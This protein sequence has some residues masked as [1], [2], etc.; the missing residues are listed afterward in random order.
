MR[1]PILRL[2]MFPIILVVARN[3]P[4]QPNFGG[5]PLG[6]DAIAARPDCISPADRALGAQMIADYRARLAEMPAGPQAVLPTA[7]SPRGTTPLLRFYPMAGNLWGDLFTT[8]FVD[9]AP[10]SPAILDWDCTNFTYDGHRG[11]DTDIRTFGEQLIG[12]P[13][14]AALDGLVVGVHDGE[15]DM[16]TSWNNQPANF[17][18]INHAGR[19]YWYYH[20][21]KDSVAVSVWDYVRAGTQIGLCG[22]SGVSTWPH[23]HFELHRENGVHFEPYA[24]PCRAGPSEWIDQTPIRRDLYLREFTITSADPGAFPPLPHNQV[25]RTGSFIQ[26]LRNISFWTIVH[27]LPAAST[28]RI[29]YRRPDATIAFDTGTGNFNN[30]DY[31]WSWWYWTRT[32]NFNQPGTWHILF[33]LNGATMIEA[34]FD[35]LPIG[36]SIVNRPPNP[37]SVALDPPAPTVDD[38]VFCRVY[39]SLVLDDPDYEIVRYEYVWLADGDEVR[40]VTSAA[41]SDA[42]PHHTAP[43]GATLQCL[44]TPKDAAASG[45]TAESSVVALPPCAEA[46]QPPVPDCN[47][48]A[49]IDSCDIDNHTSTDCN[50]NGVPD[51]C[52]PDAFDCDGDAIP[53]ICEPF[54]DCNGNNIRDNCEI[55]SGLATDC[56]DNGLPDDCDLAAGATDCDAN[57]VLDEC[58]VLDLD[59]NENGVPDGCDLITGP[60]GDCND[61]NQPDVNELQTA[62]RTLYRADSPFVD[63]LLL[64]G[65]LAQDLHF[66]GPC[67]VVGFDVAHFSNVSLTGGA[68]IVRFYSRTGTEFDPEAA[69]LA[70]F[71]RDD[72]V[73][74]RGYVVESFNL[75][76]AQRFAVPPDV[77]LE[78][79]YNQ[80]RLEFPLVSGPPSVGQSAGTLYHRPSGLYL[81]DWWTHAV[82]RA[83]LDCN[84]NGFIDEC[85]IDCNGNAVPD[86]CDIADGLLTDL[87]G[88]ALA[89]E[90]QSA[91]FCPCGDLD[92]SGGPVNL[93]DFTVFATCFG[94]A[95]PNDVCGGL[96]FDCA[97]LNDDG[98][99]NLTDFNTF[100]ALLATTP[101]GS[102]PDCLD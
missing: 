13:I 20:L 57:G 82:V 69:P 76:L 74:G 46:G 25:P 73:L 68:L 91:A 30:P 5:G 28:W 92:R 86:D 51:E 23:L 7:P 67:T 24:G 99:I 45:P 80:F 85:E 14:Y 60:P 34:P 96:P 16:N 33:D 26:G 56:N 43:A 42:L 84:A 55:S 44:V 77:W 17:V 40:R 22:S 6:D 81:S 31:R 29:R 62:T 50:L 52:D 15:F 9:L 65:A 66:D 59:C 101:T 4:A 98:V 47:G 90:C 71:S 87:N 75:S 8:N 2:L 89:D 54:D 12:V 93:T 48:N 58:D 11:N 100:A 32:V 88:D 3:A 10:G 61:N 79:E 41:H 1:L 64:E 35:V 21:K 63:Y 95:A 97:D 53:E 83:S 49:V 70:A 18:L 27:N 36:S 72:F 78:I 38:T 19:V 94:L 39:S 102:P 37:I